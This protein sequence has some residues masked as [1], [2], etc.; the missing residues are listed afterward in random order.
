[1]LQSMGS[2]EARDPVEVAGPLGTPLDP[3]AR[4][5]FM[6]ETKSRPLPMGP[7]LGQNFWPSFSYSLS[8]D[9]FPLIHF[10]YSRTS[11]K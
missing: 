2:Q 4:P 9:S 3:A 6:P 5:P 1:M 8:M 10:N 11:S 7:E